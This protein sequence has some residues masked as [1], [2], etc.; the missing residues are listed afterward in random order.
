MKLG[1]PYNIH[2][3]WAWCSAVVPDAPG[4]ALGIVASTLSA[5]RR[6]PEWAQAMVANLN[7]TAAMDAEFQAML[8]KGAA[9]LLEAFAIARMEVQ[10][11]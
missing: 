1:T 7:E 2:V 8:D 9:D 11:E 5:A 10:P 3:A 6:Y 4:V